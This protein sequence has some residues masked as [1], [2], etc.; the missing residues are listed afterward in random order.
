[1]TSNP[2][3]REAIRIAVLACRDSAKRSY[4]RTAS[5]I[6]SGGK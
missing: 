5:T 3:D 2:S 6:T 4:Q 1:L